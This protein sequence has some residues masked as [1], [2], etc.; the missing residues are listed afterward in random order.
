MLARC[1]TAGA[2]LFSVSAA[3]GYRVTGV[4]D[5]PTPEATV[6]FLSGQGRVE[7]VVR[8]LSG[9][10]HATIHRAGGNDDVGDD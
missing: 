7:V 6:T 8:C 2:S 3:P 9:V 1:S 5:G 10:P 4:S